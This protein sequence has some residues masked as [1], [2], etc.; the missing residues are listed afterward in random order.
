MPLDSG[1]PF[2]KLGVTLLALL[3]EVIIE[4]LLSGCALSEPFVSFSNFKVSIKFYF[5]SL[6]G[7]RCLLLLGL[8]NQLLDPRLMLRVERL[9]SLLGSFSS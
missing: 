1:L 4:L 2:Q 7:E 8:A 6:L 3:L 9:L 5:F